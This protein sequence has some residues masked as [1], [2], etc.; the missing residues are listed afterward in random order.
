MLGSAM[1][2]LWSL[3][4]LTPATTE[5]MNIFN[6][7]GKCIRIILL[8]FGFACSISWYPFWLTFRNHLNWNMDF[9]K[10]FKWNTYMI[11]HFLWKRGMSVH[12][13]RCLLMKINLG[14]SSRILVC[15]F[16]SC[17]NTYYLYHFSAWKLEGHCIKYRYSSLVTLVV[18]VTNK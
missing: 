12:D 9:C 16:M 4:S 18:L 13:G 11:Y 17:Y 15:K 8:V 2:P 10:I 6:N 1:A 3:H 14:M 7:S 5:W